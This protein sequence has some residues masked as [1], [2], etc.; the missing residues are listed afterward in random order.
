VIR[1]W[2]L[3]PW[4]RGPLVPPLRGIINVNADVWIE[5]TDEEM[6]GPPP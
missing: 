6:L 2:G 1:S 4:I 5:G 3:V